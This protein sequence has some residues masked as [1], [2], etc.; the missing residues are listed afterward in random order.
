MTVIFV[1]LKV[2]TSDNSVQSLITSVLEISVITVI[3]HIGHVSIT[4]NGYCINCAVYCR[5]VRMAVV[6]TMG[7]WGGGGG[8][9]NRPLTA[10]ATVVLTFLQIVLPLDNLQQKV[11]KNRPFE[12][13]ISFIHLSFFLL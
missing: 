6:G 8:A 13:T 9:R 10:A 1:I 3:L 2:I 4:I 5:A 12:F 7:C 11:K